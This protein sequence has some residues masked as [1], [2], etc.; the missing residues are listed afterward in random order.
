LTRELDEVV[1]A[2]AFVDTFFREEDFG[3]MVNGGRKEEDNEALMLIC[4]EVYF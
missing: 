4:E 2:T 3:D 1:T